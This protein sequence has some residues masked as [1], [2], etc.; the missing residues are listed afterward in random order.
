MNEHRLQAQIVKLLRASGFVTMDSDVMSALRYLPTADK[1][2][3]LFVNQHKNMGYTKGQPD[4]VVLL[5]KGRVV[6]AE[7]KN[8]TNGRQSTEQKLF[9]SEIEAM[10]HQYVVWRSVDDVADFLARQA[11]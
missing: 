1:R 4:L 6:F 11:R 7:L 5:P 3:L 8:G 2:R 9:A 10:G